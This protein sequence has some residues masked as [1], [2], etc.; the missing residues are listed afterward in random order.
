MTVEKDSN[1]FG[2]YQE[3]AGLMLNQY[4]ERKN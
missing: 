3:M 4:L 1:R 2:S